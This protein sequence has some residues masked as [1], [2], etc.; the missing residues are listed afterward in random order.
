MLNFSLCTS[1]MHTQ[2]TYSYTSPTMPLTTQTLN[3]QITEVHRI[4]VNSRLPH[5]KNSS[6]LRAVN[7]CGGV[8]AN[9]QKLRTF[10]SLSLCKRGCDVVVNKQWK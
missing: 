2:I 10:L 4:T 7:R 9:I 6:S 5:D 3:S 8:K 1:T